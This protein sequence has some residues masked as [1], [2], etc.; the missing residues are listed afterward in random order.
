MTNPS[1][2]SIQ[3]R[4]WALGWALVLL[5]LSCLPYLIALF[6]APEGWHFAGFLVNPLD[7][8]SYL[9]KMQQGAAGNWLFH[10]TYT[11]ETHQGAFI[12]VFYLALGHLARLT[13][14]PLIV[15]FHL[16][17]LTTGFF[18]LMTTW[19]FI[20]RVSPHPAEQRL[21]FV[22]L[23][24]ASG[25]GWLGAMLGA[26]PIDLWIPEAFVPYSL[27]TNPHFPLGMALMLIIFEQI[28]WPR[29]EQPGLAWRPLLEVGLPGVALALVLPF[30]LVTVVVVLAL[31]VA[32]V[33]RSQH[34]LPW[35]QIRPTLVVAFFVISILLYDYWVSTS[36]PIFAGWSAQNVTP[37]P[38]LSD[39][40]WGYGLVG[41]LA[42]VGAGLVWRSRS[43]GEQLILLWVV[44]TLLLVYAPFDLQR[45]FITGLHLPLCL[46]AAIGWH[47]WRAS[48]SLPDRWRRLFV[49]GLVTLG[50]VGTLF[51]WLVPLLSLSQ[52]PGL[53]ETNARLFVRTE[54]Q[55][56]FDWLRENTSSET[57]I[58]AGPRL[59]MFLPGQTG[60]RVF[61]GHPFE[62]I[63]AA[64]KEA[65]VRAFYRGE[66][67]PPVVVDLIIYGPDEQ[68]IGQPKNLNRYSVVFATEPIAVYE[69]KK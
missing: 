33:Y 8:H 60:A 13:G 53:S 25:L 59:G 30:A 10:L 58:L 43:E 2:S 41:L 47:R 7:G 51:V 5:L 3:S 16:A 50:A 18:L 31:Y 6:A 27:Y 29:P 14:L 56:A 44:A 15:M 9:A 40:V 62:T 61:Y 34:R 35:S 69:V 12:F 21:A 26:F 54:E 63:A 20:R 19:R 67:E 68:S 23:L 46:L 32:G 39:L 22:L 4:R 65:T 24:S 57:V 45:R 52:A 66:V 37:S 55:I 36:Q 49:T 1:P 42:V 64:Q 17:R 28:V 48:Q 38:A 11:P